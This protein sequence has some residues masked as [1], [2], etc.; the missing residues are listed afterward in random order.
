MSKSKRQRPN[1]EVSTCKPASPGKVAPPAAENTLQK[2]QRLVA[3]QLLGPN[4]GAA[5]V[6]DA[7]HRVKDDE[8]DLIAEFY[9]ELT[10]QIEKVE[11]GDLERVGAMLLVQAHMLQTIFVKCAYS[12]NEAK[13]L[14]EL[15]AYG[16]LALKTQNQCRATLATLA[17][18]KNP[19]RATFIRNTATNQ[20]VN[21]GAAPPQKNADSANELLEIKA[22]DRLDTRTP[23]EAVPV[24]TPVE[25]VAALDG[26]KDSGGQE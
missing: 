2:L 4:L 24:D 11:A 13:H 14:N 12:M 21:L 17:D 25:T 1:K 15:Q 7:F 6:I 3:Q 5:Q 23:S 20:Q 26:T 19:A 10:A 22:H 16:Q 8:V 18:I 9:E